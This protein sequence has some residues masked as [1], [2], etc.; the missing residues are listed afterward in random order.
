MYG[1]SNKYVSADVMNIFVDSL[2]SWMM[3]KVASKYPDVYFMT[4]GEIFQLSKLV[5]NYAQM[6][7]NLC[8]INKF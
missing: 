7:K 3:K 6:E 2:N 1:I 4:S 8:G 5:Q